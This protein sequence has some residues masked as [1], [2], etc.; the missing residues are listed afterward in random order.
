M[1]PAAL[2][3]CSRL[4][5]KSVSGVKSEAS[6]AVAEAIVA[7]DHGCPVMARSAAGARAGIAAMP[8]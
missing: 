7:S 5:R 6:A 3:R 4:P 8:P 1:L 2:R